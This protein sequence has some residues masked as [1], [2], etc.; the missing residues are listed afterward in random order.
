M[1]T[2]LQSVFAGKILCKGYDNKR[3]EKLELVKTDS[4]ALIADMVCIKTWT[5]VL[6]L[7]L[8]VLV[9]KIFICLIR[10][11]FW[12][13]LHKSA[14]SKVKSGITSGYI[15]VYGKVLEK[16]TSGG[17]LL[18]ELVLSLALCKQY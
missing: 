18:L 13:F 6:I 12:I 9:S 16:S 4:R 8:F 2:P 10:A 1:A 17:R 3:F 11:C 5:G 15:I 14:I 7:V